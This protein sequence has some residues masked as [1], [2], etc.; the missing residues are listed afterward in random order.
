MKHPLPEH[1][2]DLLGAL[3]IAL[4]SFGIGILVTF[5]LSARIL[6]LLEATIIVTIGFLYL[7]HRQP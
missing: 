2:P 7:R 6:V 4:T 5:F 1:R 3:A